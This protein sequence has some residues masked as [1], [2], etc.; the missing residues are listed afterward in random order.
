MPSSCLWLPPPAPTLSSPHSLHAS[1]LGLFFTG[2]TQLCSRMFSFG[3]EY[4]FTW[5]ILLEGCPMTASF[6]SFQL[7]STATLSVAPHRLKPV[8]PLQHVA[9]F[10]CLPSAHHL[11]KRS[12]FIHSTHSL[13]AYSRLCLMRWGYIRVKQRSPASWSIHI[14]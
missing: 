10:H 3:T 12:P 6:T 8:F 9:R 13:S 4:P 2:T 11:L 7:H 1:N 5:N 14:L